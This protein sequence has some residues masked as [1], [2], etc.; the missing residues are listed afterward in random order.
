MRISNQNNKPNKDAID[1]WLLF[2][3]SIEMGPWF[4]GSKTGQATPFDNTM[5]QRETSEGEKL[6][7]DDSN[8]KTS[9]VELCNIRPT[10]FIGRDFFYFQNL[11]S[12]GTSAHKVTAPAVVSSRYSLYIFLQSW[13]ALKGHL[14]CSTDKISPLPFLTFFKALQKYQKRD[15]A[16]IWFGAKI[17]ILY[18]SGERFLSV[19]T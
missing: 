7:I 11:N 5:W 17:R 12:I 10:A 3:S 8:I 13:T 14:T 2:R 18:S 19:G 15:L 1:P 6:E 9:Y 4:N 16:T